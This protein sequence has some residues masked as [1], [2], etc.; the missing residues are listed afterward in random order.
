MCL[1]HG[2]LATRHG[3]EWL[4]FTQAGRRAGGQAGG[5]A[6]RS[7]LFGP[8]LLW[9]ALVCS[10]LPW[11]G[12]LWSALVRSGPLWSGLLW[13]VVLGPVLLRPAQCAAVPFGK[14]LCGHG[15]A[16]FGFAQQ[17]AVRF[18]SIQASAFRAVRFSPVQD[19]S[20]RFNPVV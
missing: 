19:S 12:L 10:G 7:S 17:R 5:Q 11:S 18:H 13:S 15:T 6:P 14:V 1:A 9:S 2:A 3:C 20:V 16:Q 8:A 4:H